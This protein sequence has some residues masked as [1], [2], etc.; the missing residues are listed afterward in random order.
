[1]TSGLLEDMQEVCDAR[2]DCRDQ[3]QTAHTPDRHSHYPGF[4]SSAML[5]EKDYPFYWQGKSPDKRREH[6]VGFVAK[7]SLLGSIIPLAGGTEWI[8][9]LQHQTSPNRSA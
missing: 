2:K 5:R 4:C 8:L 6:G 1:M 9:K 3:Q 7:N